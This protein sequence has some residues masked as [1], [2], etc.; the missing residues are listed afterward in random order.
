VP[1]VAKRSSLT[2]LVLLLC[3]RIN[4]F[5]N[6]FVSTIN[7]FYAKLFVMLKKNIFSILLAVL[8]M[9]LSLAPSY[10]FKK[11]SLFNFPFQDKIVHFLMY[12]TLMSV[13]ILENRNTIKNNLQLFMIAIIPLFYGIL[14]EILQSTLTV[15][16]SGSVYDALFNL[17][18]IIVSLLLWLLIKPFIKSSIR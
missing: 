10:T 8:I 3:K 14:M 1:V 12:F 11:V 6:I 16:R 9:Y 2:A 17:A 7:Y 4:S 5:N 15:S 18:G 13:L